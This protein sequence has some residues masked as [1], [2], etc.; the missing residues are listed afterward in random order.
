[1]NKYKICNTNKFPLKIFT[2]QRYIC[3][4]YYTY[5]P[6][7]PF[8]GNN[9]LYTHTYLHNY[10]YHH[11]CVIGKTKG[12][13]EQQLSYG[14]PKQM[15]MIVMAQHLTEIDENTRQIGIKGNDKLFSSVFSLLNN[16]FFIILF[17]FLFYIKFLFQHI[18]KNE[19]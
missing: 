9:R 14:A 16:S 1:M 4:F 3:V 7:Y 15:E 8:K 13:N 12:E 18:Y 5:K 2:G 17:H 6:Q 11:I 19:I 10:S